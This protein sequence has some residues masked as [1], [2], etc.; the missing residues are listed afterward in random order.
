MYTCL[1]NIKHVQVKKK[2]QNS[3]FVNG[4]AQVAVSGESSEALQ[5]VKLSITNVVLFIWNGAEMTF[6]TSLGEASSAL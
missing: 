6:S 5:P 2:R 4:K 1:S 3:T